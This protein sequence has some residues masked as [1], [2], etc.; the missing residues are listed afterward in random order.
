MLRRAYRFA[1]TPFAF[2]VALACAPQA[3]AGLTEADRAAIQRVS[4]EFVQ[5]MTNADFD[6][7]SALYTEDALVL[8][9][10]GPAV[11]GRAAI[12]GFFRSFPPVSNFQLTNI[13]V[14]GR[15]DLAFVHGR[16]SMT[17]TM[18]DGSQVADSGKYLEIR[19]R[20]PDGRWLLAYDIFNSDV[21]LPQP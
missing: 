12:A 17:L 20:Q 1:L 14:D 8:P 18:P 21:P 9:P 15:G 16:Y 11:Q 19:R 5:H 7:G 6:A 10:N 13:T 3:P 4:E 2:G